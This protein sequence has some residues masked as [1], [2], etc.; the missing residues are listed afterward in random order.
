MKRKV[1]QIADSTQLVSLPRKWALK[2]GI[3][4]GDEIEVEEKG[5]RLEII[6][7]HG[8]HMDKVNV[9]FDKFSPL[10]AK[11][12]LDVLHKCGYDEIEINY[13]DKVI[14]KAI[15]ERLLQYIGCDVVEQSDKRV[16]IKDITQGSLEGEFDSLFRRAFMV[17]LS[18][19]KSSLDSIKKGVYTEL[20]EYALMESTNNKVVNYCQ[21]ILSKK[22]HKDPKKVQLYYT[23]LWYLESVADDFRDLLNYISSKKDIKL[24]KEYVKM[25]EDVTKYF[26]LFHDTFFKYDKAS[27]DSLYTDRNKIIQQGVTLFKANKDE[28]EAIW[29]LTSIPHKLFDVL[30]IISGIS[31]H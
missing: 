18:M 27:L 8:Q 11:C 7:G 25:Y 22:G 1:I 15:Q 13:T 10:T 29:Y 26:Q 23:M 6:S 17:T 2:Y 30:P 16:V 19:A 14:F 4:K 12:A 31:M 5:N 3:R 24:S 20:G 28:P 21:R 9:D